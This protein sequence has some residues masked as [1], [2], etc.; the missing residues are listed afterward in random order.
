MAGP[1]PWIWISSSTRIEGD[2]VCLLLVGSL[3]DSIPSPPSPS[4]SMWMMEGALGGG[5]DTE[6]GTTLATGPAGLL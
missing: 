6:V 4:E 5:L 3:P 2:L 1:L